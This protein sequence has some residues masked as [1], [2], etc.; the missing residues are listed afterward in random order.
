MKDELY[1][2]SSIV[3]AQ[4]KIEHDGIWLWIRDDEPLSLSKRVY[5]VPKSICSSGKQAEELIKDAGI[6]W[7]QYDTTNHCYTSPDG[8]RWSFDDKKGVLS[9]RILSGGMPYL[10]KWW[11]EQLLKHGYKLPK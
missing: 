10:E 5:L 2:I 8:T 7:S 3:N 1:G 11:S 6:Q 4:F 9:I